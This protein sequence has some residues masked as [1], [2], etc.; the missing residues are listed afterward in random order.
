MGI[1]D[2]GEP[3]EWKGFEAYQQLLEVA[4]RSFGAFR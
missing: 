2:E 1:L 3:R 4:S